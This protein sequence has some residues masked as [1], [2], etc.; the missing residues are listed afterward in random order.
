M[1]KILTLVITTLFIILPLSADSD[2]GLFGIS[3]GYTS[4]DNTALMGF[5]GTYQYSADVN[6]NIS[7]GFGTHAD[8]A[9]GLNHD[10]NLSIFV[11]TVF[12][13]GLDAKL[14]DALSLNVTAG[15]VVVAETGISHASVGI[16]IGVDAALSYYFDNNRTVGFSVGTTIYPQFFVIDDIRTDNFSIAAMGYIGMSF[17]YPSPVSVF[18]LPAVAYLL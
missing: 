6:N 15:P 10:D 8:F 1:R 18:A 17:R 7:I 14:T 2:F 9:F 11:G 5:N 3:G 12:G 16:G 13:V 4:K